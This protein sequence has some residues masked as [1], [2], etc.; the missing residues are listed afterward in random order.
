MTRRSTLMH[1]NAS[2][3]VSHISCSLT[4]ASAVNGPIESYA[5]QLSISPF[6]LQW[7][8]SPCASLSNPH[9]IVFVLQFFSVEIVLSVQVGKVPKNVGIGVD[10]WEFL[11]KC[12][13]IAFAF[14]DFDA[15]S[16][17][18]LIYFT[19]D[20]SS[21]AGLSNWKL[22]TRTRYLQSLPGQ[23]L[24]S[25]KYSLKIHSLI[26]ASE[27]YREL[28]VNKLAVSA[29]TSNQSVDGLQSDNNSYHDFRF[30]QYRCWWCGNLLQPRLHLYPTEKV[31]GSVEV[32][33]RCSIRWTGDAFS[34]H[35]TISTFAST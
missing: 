22:R 16:T 2:V 25:S 21:Y 13:L 3:N 35:V 11:H 10:V 14:N 34:D 8:F 6:N 24:Q 18:G 31:S 27:F 30:T 1:L 7:K 29:S 28:V 15:W 5:P 12:H 17:S 9:R 32:V 26:K 19:F 20:T 4:A 33:G 23:R